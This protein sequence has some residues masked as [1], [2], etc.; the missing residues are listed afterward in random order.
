MKVLDSPAGCLMALSGVTAVVLW[1]RWLRPWLFTRRQ[2]TGLTYKLYLLCSAGHNCMSGQRLPWYPSSACICTYAG[3]TEPDEQLKLEPLQDTTRPGLAEL[4]LQRPLISFDLETTGFCRAGEYI[5]EIAA[6][7]LFPDGH[8]EQLSTL[9]KPP[10]S[11]PPGATKVNTMTHP[12]GGHLLY[13]SVQ[14]ALSALRTSPCAL[15]AGAWHH[16]R[17]MCGRPQLCS[18]G[19]AAPCV[20]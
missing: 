13:P 11:I 6:I 8:Q 4:Q 20:L 16:R 18:A 14:S 15:A 10:K 12:E 2:A 1:E 5:V 17:G 9:V 7:K 19:S 3:D